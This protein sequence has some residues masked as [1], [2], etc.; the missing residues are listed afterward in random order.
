MEFPDEISLGFHWETKK[1]K[2]FKRAASGAKKTKK[3]QKRKP[4]VS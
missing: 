4:P 2:E 1:Q 3:D